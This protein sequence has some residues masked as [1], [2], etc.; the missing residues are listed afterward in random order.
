MATFL[1]LRDTSTP[2]STI[3]PI[4]KAVI[5]KSEIDSLNFGFFYVISEYFTSWIHYCIHIMA[6]MSSVPPINTPMKPYPDVS[7]NAMYDG[8]SGIS[9]VHFVG[10]KAAS[11]ISCHILSTDCLTVDNFAR[12]TH[13]FPHPSTEFTGANTAFYDGMLIVAW[14]HFP[15][16]E[17]NVLK[18]TPPPAAH[19]LLGIVK[20]MVLVQ[21]TYLLR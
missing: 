21:C 11:C 14:R 4:S 19:F 8:S 20:C 1:C 7:M 5:S 15:I 3:H 9:S 16:T 6:Y 18:S 10:S 2:S 17:Q 12:F 13:D